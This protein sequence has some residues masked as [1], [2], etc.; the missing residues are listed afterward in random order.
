MYA[1]RVVHE[2]L[3]HKPGRTN[4]NVPGRGG[5][6]GER[7]RLRAEDRGYFAARERRVPDTQRL[8]RCCLES[9]MR[10]RP[11]SSGIVVWVV[12]T[13]RR[14]RDCYRR[15]AGRRI[16]LQRS[17]FRG[18]SRTAACGAR[19]RRAYDIATAGAAR[20]CRASHAQCASPPSQASLQATLLKCGCYGER[21]HGQFRNGPHQRPQCPTR[22]SDSSAAGS[23]RMHDGVHASAVG[24]LVCVGHGQ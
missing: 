23:S 5:E 10:T 20:P 19:E 3:Y 1:F 15:G 22:K 11:A 21:G 6:R 8:A 18:T 9:T 12:A 7:A 16:R 4:T 13:L 24:T 17:G 2:G 14:T